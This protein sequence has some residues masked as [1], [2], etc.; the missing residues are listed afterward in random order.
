MKQNLNKQW[1]FKAITLCIIIATLVWLFNA[2]NQTYTTHITYPVIFK[3]S[4]SE[5]VALVP[6]PTSLK[7]EV[8]GQGWSV[9]NKNIGIGV[10]PIIIDLL[11]VLKTKKF[12]TKRLLPH[13]TASIKDLKINHIIP[14]TLILHYDRIIAKKI[15]ICLL[16]EQIPTKDG[17]RLTSKIEINPKQIIFR[18]AFTVLSAFPDTLFLKLEEEDIEN[19]YEQTVSIIYPSETP[20][21]Y[22]ETNKVKVSFQTSFFVQRNLLVPV[23]LVNFPLDSSVTIAEKSIIFQYWFKKENENRIFADTIKAIVDFKNRNLSD[24]T[25]IPV[26][27]LPKEIENINFTPSKIKLI[28]AKNAKNRDNRRNRGR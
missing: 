2:L 9:L 27:Y 17:Y 15:N 14:D 18:G 22:P 11:N 21:V 5:V 10:E 23:H 28:Y 1:D 8:T 16:P 19:D 6:P 12:D 26:A 20:P 3:T 7:L 24:S 25:I 4:Q 13:L